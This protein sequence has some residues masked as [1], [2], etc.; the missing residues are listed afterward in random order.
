MSVT[1]NGAYI[2]KTYED[3][4]M[5]YIFSGN[6]DNNS[7][8]DNTD[9]TEKPDGTEDSEIPDDSNGIED[10]DVTGYTAKELAQETAKQERE[11]RKIDIRKRTAE[12]ELTN[13]EEQLADGVVRSKVNG[14]VKTVHDIE[15]IPTDG[16]AVIGVSGTAG[17]DIEG[18]VSELMLDKIKIGQGVTAYDWE[19]G[20]NY[21]GQISE[22]DVVPTN[23]NSYYGEGN[24]NVSYYGYTAYIE[25]P[26][27]LMAGQY[28][29]L[30]I[31]NSDNSNQDKLYIQQ[32]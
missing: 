27:G 5:V 32:C 13:L 31:E 10:G 8:A 2:S 14:V 25:D 15:D 26:S 4:D 18:S 20:N 19:S 6:H 7:D 17:L 12:N 29:Q 3:S 9:N 28:L 1:M 30:T 16:S 23:N 21:Q 11:V 24:P 22:I